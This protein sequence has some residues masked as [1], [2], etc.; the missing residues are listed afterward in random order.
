M[1]EHYSPATIQLAGRKASE[2][3][4]RPGIRWPKMMIYHQ[5]R[6]WGNLVRWLHLCLQ[7]S[8]YACH[9][10][11]DEE[12]AEYGWDYNA[13]ESLLGGLF[14]FVVNDKEPTANRLDLLLECM[15]PALIAADKD[16]SKN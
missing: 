12:L 5:Q 16:W 3:D 10:V 8:R 1:I 4:P 11:P 2:A 13:E 6:H 7:E 9:L 15:R 14:K